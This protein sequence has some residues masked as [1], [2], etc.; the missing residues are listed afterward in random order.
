MHFFAFKSY[1][2]CLFV[3]SAS[4]HLPSAWIIF[5]NYLKVQREET[6]SKWLHFILSEG[7]FWCKTLIWKEKSDLVSQCDPFLVFYATGFSNVSINVICAW[8]YHYEYVPSVLVFES[9]AYDLYTDWFVARNIHELRSFLTDSFA[10]LLP[11]VLTFGWCFRLFLLLLHHQYFNWTIL[12]ARFMMPC[13]D[14]TWVGKIKIRKGLSERGNPWKE[15]IKI[16]VCLFV[17]FLRHRELYAFIVSVS[18]SSRTL[19]FIFSP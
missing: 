12:I 18:A 17:C 8:L 10:T 13:L 14:K 5:A 6:L 11:P 2:E 3:W 19:I 15:Q 1:L 16:H 9:N 4:L 7:S